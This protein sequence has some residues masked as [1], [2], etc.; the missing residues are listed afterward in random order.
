MELLRQGE[1][2]LEWSDVKDLNKKWRESSQETRRRKGACISSYWDTF[3]MH[4]RGKKKKWRCKITTPKHPDMTMK[5]RIKSVKSRF[6]LW[7]TECGVNRGVFKG[8]RT[9]R[10]LE[11]DGALQKTV[12][13]QRRH[14]GGV[15]NK[16][17]TAGGKPVLSPWTCDSSSRRGFYSSAWTQT[18]HQIYGL[19]SDTREE[20]Q[21]RG[22]C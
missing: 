12:C 15:L 22:T 7:H 11:E 19:S 2:I 14:A 1:K 5:A 17:V 16:I 6:W 21:P 3:E 18:R 13:C 4:E 8:R 20:S 10:A 9:R